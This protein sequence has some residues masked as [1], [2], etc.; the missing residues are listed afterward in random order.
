MP[1]NDVPS[2]PAPGNPAPGDPV[3][4][5][6]KR[7]SF[8]IS[9]VLG[10]IAVVVLLGFVGSSTISRFSSDTPRP[11]PPTEAEA[12]EVL[13]KQAAKLAA[14]PTKQAYC[15][16]NAFCPMAWDQAG[17]DAAVPKTPP[18]VLSATVSESVQVLTVCGRDG[19]GRPYQSQFPVWTVG[20]GPVGIL[21]VYWGNTP[22]G[23]TQTAAALPAT[24][25]PAPTPS[26]PPECG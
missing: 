23:G 17:G 8:S 22:F 14:N 26:N 16:D 9:N 25:T 10:W 19:R 15:G 5:A 24:P 6:G 18:H 21:L 11:G 4:R 1:S 7:P 13:A 2:N 12:R 3:P 20:D